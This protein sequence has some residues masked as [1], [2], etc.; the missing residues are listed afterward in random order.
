MEASCGAC[1]EHIVEHQMFVFSGWIAHMECVVENVQGASEFG[2]WYVWLSPPPCQPICR[3]HGS[4]KK[5]L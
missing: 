2:L 5:V 3:P 4:V 1:G